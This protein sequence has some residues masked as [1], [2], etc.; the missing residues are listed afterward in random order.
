MGGRFFLVFLRFNPN[1]GVR[2][3]EANLETEIV[4]RPAAAAR[5]PRVGFFF[6]VRP[7]D[8]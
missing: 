3:W 1:V 6:D 8:D 2:F 4:A 7:L 5:P